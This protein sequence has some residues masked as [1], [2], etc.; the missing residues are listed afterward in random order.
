MM[1]DETHNN[2]RHTAVLAVTRH[3][4]HSEIY[5]LLCL[6][7][8]AHVV[9]MFVVHIDYLCSRIATIDLKGYCILL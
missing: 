4:I 1:D 6:P 5:D 2:K 3:D 9:Q 8:H 7:I